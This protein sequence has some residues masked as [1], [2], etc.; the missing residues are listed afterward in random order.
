MKQETIDK[1]L[2]GQYQRDP[3]KGDSNGIAMDNIISR[4]RLF[5]GNKDVM[6]ISS[7]GK[8]KGTEVFLYLTDKKKR[9]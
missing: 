9:E 3:A 4:L 2:S 1:I 6:G 7:D 5:T 8:G